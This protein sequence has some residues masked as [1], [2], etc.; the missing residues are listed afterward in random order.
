MEPLLPQRK[1]VDRPDDGTVKALRWD[2]EM[3]EQYKDLLK[4]PAWE[5]LAAQMYVVRDAHIGTLVSGEGDQTA[6]R[7]GIKII[8]KILMAPQVMIMLGD[9]SEK[10][11]RRMA[12]ERNGVNA[13]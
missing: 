1:Q 5:N 7:E 9:E 3:G 6:A 4:H 11:L 2:Y 8:D 13:G 12:A 10:D